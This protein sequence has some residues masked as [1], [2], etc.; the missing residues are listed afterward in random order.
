MLGQNPVYHMVANPSGNPGEF[1]VY[2]NWPVNASNT[3]V[4]IAAGRV[5]MFYDTAAGSSPTITN[6]QGIWSKDQSLT[7]AQVNTC[8][9]NP[10]TFA[11]MDFNNTS[12]F[13]I[14]NVASGAVD[15]LFRLK[16][17]G[18]SNLDS[19]R[20]LEGVNGAGGG[21]L[22]NCLTGVGFQ[23][24]LR[25]R[26]VSSPPNYS[27]INISQNSTSLPLPVE[28]LSLNVHKDGKDAKII[29]LTSSELN[30]DYFEIERSE[31]ALNWES[32]GTTISKA[33]NGF[34]NEI[35]KYEYVDHSFGRS[36]ANV[37]Y[38]RIIQYDLDGKSDFFGPVF[39]KRNDL[40]FDNFLL[41]PNPVKERVVLRNKQLQQTIENIGIEIFNNIGQE[42]PYTSMNLLVEEGI[43]INLGNLPTGHYFMI[44]KNLENQSIMYSRRFVKL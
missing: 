26:P 42:Q 24:T 19:V 10:N 44:I 3:N 18:T 13:S 28:L 39:L 9:S 32:I 35:L 43:E 20:L 5:T 25:Y 33:T 12:T 4:S 17:S 22:D 21:T 23:A 36:M 34:S 1:V 38:Y 30:N 14:G 8:G 2:L 6:V 40:S 29:W 27:T 16:F 7:I 37:T 41:Y 11:Y 31:D 15:T